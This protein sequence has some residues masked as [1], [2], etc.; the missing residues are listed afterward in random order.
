MA[1]FRPADRIMLSLVVFNHPPDIGHSHKKH[2]AVNINRKGTELFTAACIA[3]TSCQGPILAPRHDHNNSTFSVQQTDKL[4]RFTPKK[5]VGIDFTV[6][7]NILNQNTPRRDA[8]TPT[9]RTDRNTV[10]YESE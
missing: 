3:P 9:V 8:P 1:L 10:R 7:R 4:R 6:T 5:S 2:Y